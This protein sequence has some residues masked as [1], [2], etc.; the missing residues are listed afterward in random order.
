MNYQAGS[1]T[2][3]CKRRVF[4]ESELE[5]V[6]EVQK[7]ALPIFR[8]ILDLLTDPNSF[9]VEKGSKYRI[10]WPSPA[11]GW[12]LIVAASEPE[13]TSEDIQ[14]HLH[15]MH[16]ALEEAL[17][18]ERSGPGTKVSKLQAIDLHHEFTEHSNLVLR[19]ALILFKNRQD[20]HKRMGYSSES[21]TLLGDRMCLWKVRLLFFF[22]ATCIQLG[23]L[24]WAL[25]A[26][27]MAMSALGTL[28]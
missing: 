4:S 15:H 28:A 7:Y 13:Q 2:T 11:N 1:T 25:P 5:R 20:M 12:Q 14:V 22:S 18:A 27:E 21:I 24:R 17:R 26:T 8:P 6:N 16:R 10:G 19:T 9:E 3:S 23:I